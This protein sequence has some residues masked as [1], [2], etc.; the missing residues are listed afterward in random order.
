MVL[1][2]LKALV[3]AS[4]DMRAVAWAAP[5]AAAWLITSVP[6]CKSPSSSDIEESIPPTI[7]V[8]CTPTSG[9]RGTVVI[10]TVSVK[11]VSQEIKSFGLEVTFEAQMFA[12]QSIAKGNLTQDWA[13]VD[14]FETQ[15][16]LIKAGGFAGGGTPVGK[17]STGSLMTVR[18]TVTCEGCASGRQSQVCIQNLAD[19]IKEMRLEPSCALFTYT[20]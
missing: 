3:T 9:G 8:S 16:G 18:F 10:V 7:S 12:F 2:M 1:R 6:G 14:G 5:L 13:S 11:G 4:L 20:Q 17:V 15:S 19:N